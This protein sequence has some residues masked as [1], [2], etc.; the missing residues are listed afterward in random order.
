MRLPEDS[1]SGLLAGELEETK[2]TSESSK[3]FA[4]VTAPLGGIVSTSIAGLR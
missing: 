1:E 3:P 4:G 2:T